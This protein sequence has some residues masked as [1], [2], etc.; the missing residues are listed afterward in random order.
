[1]P[2]IKIAYFILCHK[3]PEHVIRLINRLRAE[4]S[5][6]IIHID[7]RADPRVYEMLKD[8]SDNLP[9]V[10]FSKRH[11]CYWGRFGIVRATISC[12]QEAILLDIPFDYAFLLSGQDYPIKTGAQIAAFIAEHP[13]REFIETFPLDEPNRWSNESPPGN[14]LN[15]VKFWT[16]WFR[17]RFI[18]VKG[19]R[20]FPLGNRPYGGSQWWCLSRECLM[21]LDT[22]VRNHP[23][24]LR[25]FKWVFVPDEMFFQSILSNSGYRNKIESDDLRYADWQNPNPL[26]P[27]TLDMNDFEKLKLS[28]KL[29]ARKFDTAVSLELLERLDNETVC[30]NSKAAKSS[31]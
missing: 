9:E 29:F 23:S 22:F 1:M 16:I 12:I 4:G 20:R 15:R 7:K 10:H 8:F 25:F 27:R 17:S 3:M 6:F 31:G 14:S 13:R 28:T 21:Y 19:R 5:L 30:T 24:F 26:S 11:R 2:Q 18:Q